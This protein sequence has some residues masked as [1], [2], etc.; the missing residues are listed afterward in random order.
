MSVNFYAFHNFCL[1]VCL[2]ISL[3]ENNI[4]SMFSFS[5]GKPKKKSF[6]TSGPTT[7]RGRG[8]EK[9]GPL[10]K[11]NFFWSAKNFLKDSS[12]DH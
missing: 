7:K 12:D 6:S 9:A 11:N 3:I 8:R 2:D 5:L 4:A 1:F 10:R